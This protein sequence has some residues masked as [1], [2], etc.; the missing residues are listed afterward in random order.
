MAMN[1]SVKTTSRNF[2]R[3]TFTYV[4]M[5][6]FTAIPREQGYYIIINTAM[7]FQTQLTT[8]SLSLC[9]ASAVQSL[10]AALLIL[11]LLLLEKK[12]WYK[13]MRW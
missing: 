5:V 13:H 10:A 3:G 8:D 1:I 12:K 11:I 7:L 9:V 4:T 2:W 6:T